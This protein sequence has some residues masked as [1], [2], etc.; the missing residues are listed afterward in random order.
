MEQLK[1]GDRI[2][3]F[4]VLEKGQKYWSECKNIQGR[5]VA[6]IHPNIPHENCP[7]VFIHNGC[8]FINLAINLEQAKQVCTMVITKLK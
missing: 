5:H 1:V 3:V 6:E 8:D 2:R 4:E 7:D